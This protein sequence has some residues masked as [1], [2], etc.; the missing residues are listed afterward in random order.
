MVLDC[1]HPAGR[2]VIPVAKPSDPGF[3]ACL[4]WLLQQTYSISEPGRAASVACR[5]RDSLNSRVVSWARQIQGSP[6]GSYELDKCNS[7]SSL[8]P[9]LALA[10]LSGPNFKHIVVYG[11]VKM[12]G[13][14]RGTI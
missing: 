4:K 11:M 2:I 10:G 5:R 9:I 3:L 7:E 1:T 14:N 12:L 8:S 13:M 6:K